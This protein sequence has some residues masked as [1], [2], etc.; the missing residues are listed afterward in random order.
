[1][2]QVK[3]PLQ[4]IRQ[5]NNN[6]PGPGVPFTGKLG[7]NIAQGSRASENIGATSDRFDTFDI[8]SRTHQGRV[9][10]TTECAE[11]R[12]MKLSKEAMNDILAGIWNEESD[13]LCTCSTKSARSLVAS[14][15]TSVNVANKVIP[16]KP[17]KPQEEEEK[18]FVSKLRWKK[19]KEPEPEEES[20]WSSSDDEGE[21]RQTYF[22]TQKKFGFQLPVQQPDRAP[23][24]TTFLDEKIRSSQIE[25][26][27]EY[28]RELGALNDELTSGQRKAEKIKIGA[29]GYCWKSFLFYSHENWLDPNFPYGYLPPG[30]SYHVLTTGGI[31]TLDRLLEWMRLLMPTVIEMEKSKYNLRIYELTWKDQVIHITAHPALHSVKNKST[32]LKTAGYASLSSLPDES[33]LLT[34][35][36]LMRTFK[37]MWQ[38]GGCV[39]KEKKGKITLTPKSRSFCWHELIYYKET[40]LFQS[41]RKKPPSMIRWNQGMSNKTQNALTRH[42]ELLCGGSYTFAMEKREHGIRVKQMRDLA[43]AINIEKFIELAEQHG[44]SYLHTR[45]VSEP[46]CWHLE[47]VEPAVI[48]IDYSHNP[49]D[50]Y[51]THTDLV[52]CIYGAWRGDYDF[53]HARSAETTEIPLIGIDPGYLLENEFKTALGLA[54]GDEASTMYV[55]A[56]DDHDARVVNNAFARIELVKVKTAAPDKQLIGGAYAKSTRMTFVGNRVT[57]ND[58]NYEFLSDVCASYAYNN[59]VP[60]ETLWGEETQERLLNQDWFILGNIKNKTR[61]YVTTTPDLSNTVDCMFTHCIGPVIGTADEGLL[62]ENLGWYKYVGGQLRWAMNNTTLAQTCGWETP[63]YRGQESVEVNGIHVQCVARRRFH[64]LQIITLTCQKYNTLTALDIADAT[65]DIPIFSTVGALAS[66][67]VPIITTKSVTLNRDLL[68]RLMTK[69]VTGKVS[70]DKLLEYGM[71]LSWFSYSKRGVEISNAKVTD[72]DVYTHVYVAKILQARE[73]LY[74][75]VTSTLTSPGLPRVLL[76]AAAAMFSDAMSTTDLLDRVRTSELLSKFMN[77]LKTPTIRNATGIALKNWLSI[78]AWSRA[79]TVFE[80]YKDGVAVC[81]HHDWCVTDVTGMYCS[82]CHSPTASREGGRCECCQE[83]PTFCFHETHRSNHVIGEK[84]C[85]CC[86]LKSEDDICKDCKVEV[87]Q[88]TVGSKAEQQIQGAR[89]F[90]VTRPS[91]QPIAINILPVSMAAMATIVPPNAYNILSKRCHLHEV[92]HIEK[93]TERQSVIPFIELGHKMEPLA[94]FTI[95]EVQDAGVGECGLDCINYYVAGLVSESAAFGITKKT[96]NFS[97]RDLL[98]ILAHFGLNGAVADA[99]GVSFRRCSDRE[100]F[101]TIVHTK[102]V[103]VEDDIQHWRIA[104]FKW[105]EGATCSMFAASLSSEDTHVTSCRS[106]FKKPWDVATEEEKCYVAYVLIRNQEVSIKTPLG[107]PKFEHG[108]LL[109]SSKHDPKNGMYNFEV[110]T[111]LASYARDMTVALDTRAVPDSLI[112]IWDVSLEHI[113]DVWHNVRNSFRDAC[114]AMTLF[115]N[116]PMK[117][118][119]AQVRPV[120]TTV[121]DQAH[122]VDVSDMKLKN[123]DLVMVQRRTSFT[124]YVV[125]VTNNRISVESKHLSG[126]TTMTIVKPKASFMSQIMRLI[127]LCS[128]KMTTGELRDMFQA[129]NIK[130]LKGMGGTGKTRNLVETLNSG[131]EKTLAIACTSGARKTL[132]A[133]TKP[134]DNLTLESF[135]KATYKTKEDYELIVIDEGTLIRPWELALVCK[136]FKRLIVAGDPTQISDVDFSPSGGQRWATNLLDFLG[137]SHPTTSLTKTYRFGEGLVRELKKHEALRTI[138]CG[139]DKITGVTMRHLPAWRA[140]EILEMALQVD[141]VIVFYNDH[142]EKMKKLLVRHT[143]PTVSTIGSFQGEGAKTVLVIQAPHV[144]ADIHLNFGYCFSA[145]TRCEEQLIWL[146]IDCFEPT[147][148]LH[149]RIGSRIGCDPQWFACYSESGPQ[150]LLIEGEDETREVVIMESFEQL[151][152]DVDR[153]IRHRE[154]D[155]ECFDFEL[156]CRAITHY[157]PFVKCETKFTNS[158]STFVILFRSM[159]LTKDLTFD[160]KTK[161][162]DLENAPGKY[163]NQLEALLC[164]CCIP[165]TKNKA[166]IVYN[167][168]K[169]G[170]YRMRILCWLIKAYKANG[171]QWQP[172]HGPLSNF[173]FSTI[174]NACAACSGL[175]ITQGNSE[176]VVNHDYLASNSRAVK[177]PHAELFC[178]EIEAEK[179][180]M[181]PDLFDDPELSHAI[182]TERIMTWFKDLSH[183]GT[184]LQNWMWYHKFDNKLLAA[185][186]KEDMGITVETTNYDDMAA[187]P[188]VSSN[189]AGIKSYLKFKRKKWQVSM[190][191]PDTS[192]RKIKEYDYEPDLQ[193]LVYISLAHL[194]SQMK[195]KPECRLIATG[196]MKR[197]GAETSILPGMAENFEWHARH[198]TRTLGIVRNKLAKLKISALKDETKIIYVPST[199]EEYLSEHIKDRGFS[200]NQRTSPSD[201]GPVGCT[202]ALLRRVRGHTSG[203]IHSEG[204]C[205]YSAYVMESENITCYWDSSSDH[206]KLQTRLDRPVYVAMLKYHGRRLPP[207]GAEYKNLEKEVMGEGPWFTP[208]KLSEKK[209]VTLSASAN[210][211]SLSAQTVAEMYRDWKDIFAWCPM[212][213][214]RQGNNKY[215][216]C[217]DSNRVYRVHDDQYDALVNGKYLIN[218]NL[219]W[220][221][222]SMMGT[223][224]VLRLCT[225]PVWVDNLKLSNSLIIVRVPTIILDP[226]QALVTGNILSFS[227]KSFNVDLLNNLLRRCLRPGTTFDDL[228]VQLRTLINTAQFSTHT[229]SSKYKTNVA[230]GKAT[231]RLAWMT[232][233]ATVHQYSILGAET[234]NVIQPQMIGALLVGKAVDKATSGTE[235]EDGLSKLLSVTGI[236][237][238]KMPMLMK[239]VMTTLKNLSGLSTCLRSHKRRVVLGNHAVMDW[240][241]KTMLSANQPL[242]EL[243]EFTG[244]GYYWRNDCAIC[245]KLMGMLATQ[246]IDKRARALETD[247]LGWIAICSP[248]CRHSANRLEVAYWNDGAHGKDTLTLGT[249]DSPAAVDIRVSPTTNETMISGADIELPTELHKYVVGQEYPTATNCRIHITGLTLEVEL[250]LAAVFNSTIIYSRERECGMFPEYQNNEVLFL[251]ANGVLQEKY[252]RKGFM[253]RPH[254]SAKAL[255]NIDWTICTPGDWVPVEISTNKIPMSPGEAALA[256]TKEEFM[257]LY[258]LAIGVKRADLERTCW[259]RLMPVPEGWSTAAWVHHGD[260]PVPGGFIAHVELLFEYRWGTLGWNAGLREEQGRK[261]M[262]YTR[263]S[264]KRILDYPKESRSY[265]PETGLKQLTANLVTLEAKGN[266]KRYQPNKQA[267]NGTKINQLG[268]HADCWGLVR[269]VGAVC[270]ET[271]AQYLEHNYERGF[272]YTSQT[273]AG[274]ETTKTQEDVRLGEL[275]E[276]PLVNTLPQD[277]CKH[278]SGHDGPRLTVWYNPLAASLLGERLGPGRDLLSTTKT[279]FVAEHLASG[280]ALTT[281]MVLWL[282]AFREKLYEMKLHESAIVNLY[283]LCPGKAMRSPANFPGRHVHIGARDEHIT[284]LGY[285]TLELLQ[286][287]GRFGASLRVLAAMLLPG[288]VLRMMRS[289]RPSLHCMYSEEVLSHLH[290]LGALTNRNTVVGPWR[291]FGPFIDGMALHKPIS[292]ANLSRFCAAN[293]NYGHVYGMDEANFDWFELDTCYYQPANQ[294][295]YSNMPLNPQL[296]QVQESINMKPI[297]DEMCTRSTLP[298]SLVLKSTTN[299]AELWPLVQALDPQV[300]DDSRGSPTSSSLSGRDKKLM[301][302][303]TEQAQETV[304]EPAPQNPAQVNWPIGTLSL[305]YDS[306][307]TKMG[308]GETANLGAVETIMSPDQMGG[309]VRDVWVHATRLRRSR[310]REERKKFVLDELTWLNMLR[311]KQYEDTEKIMQLWGAC[312]LNVGLITG[313]HFKVNVIN[314]GPIDWLRITAHRDGY[315][316]C[317]LVSTTRFSWS[318]VTEIKFVVTKIKSNQRPRD[319][320]AHHRAHEIRNLLATEEPIPKT[321]EKIADK[322][323]NG[324][325]RLKGRFDIVMQSNRGIIREECTTCLVETEDANK[326]HG[327]FH[328]TLIPGRLYL[329]G[330]GQSL[331]WSVATTIDD[332]TVICCESYPLVI[333]DVGVALDCPA[334]PLDRQILTREVEQLGFINSASKKWA[335]WHDWNAGVSVNP[336]A[337][338]VL[339]A[340]FDNVNH[341]AR[342]D[343]DHMLDLARTRV[344]FP[345]EEIWDEALFTALGGGG[346]IR[347]GVEDGLPKLVTAANKPGD[348]QSL[349]RI[350]DI[351]ELETEFNYPDVVAAWDRVA[352][353]P[354]G[355]RLEPQRAQVLLEL[356]EQ[357]HTLTDTEYEENVMQYTLIEHQEGTRINHIV[358]QVYEF[359]NFVNDDHIYDIRVDT[360]RELTG[361][362]VLEQLSLSDPHSFLTLTFS[363]IGAGYAKMETENEAILIDELGHEGAPEFTHSGKETKSSSEEQIK[364]DAFDEKITPE[365]EQT[366]LSI[367][368]LNETMFVDPDIIMSTTFPD[369]TKVY[370]QDDLIVGGGTATDPITD[371]VIQEL[372][373]PS[374]INFWDDETGMIETVLD[375][376]KEDIRLR[377][378]EGFGGIANVIKLKTREWPTHAQGIYNSKL[379]G[380]WQAVS[381]LFGNVL[382]LREVNRD[383]KTDADRFRRIYFKTGSDK[384]LKPVGWNTATI[385]DWLST[386]PDGLSITKEVDQILSEGFDVHGLDQVN[387]HTKLESRM[388]D[389]MSNLLTVSPLDEN[390]YT[391]TISEQVSRLIVWQRKGITAL[392]SAGFLQAKE[393]LKRVL[394]PQVIYSDGYTPRQLSAR[395]NKLNGEGVTFV[396]DDLAKQDRQTDMIQIETEMLIYE[397]LGCSKQMI[398]TW[399]KVHRHWKAKG[400]NIRFD[401]DAG[402]LTGQASTSIGNTI[403]NLNV[404]ADFVERFMASLVIM[405]VLGDDNM[406]IIRGV[407]T[408]EEVMLHSARQHNMVSKPVIS[409]VGGNFL[410]MTVYTNSNGQLEVGPDFVRMSRRHQVFNGNG[411][412]PEVN[413]AIGMGPGHGKT[414]LATRNPLM[415]VDHEELCDLQVMNSFNEQQQRAETEFELEKITTKK[416]AYISSMATIEKTRGRILLTWT[417]KLVSSKFFYVTTLVVKTRTSQD[418]FRGEQQRK[419]EKRFKTKTGNWQPSQGVTF[420]DSYSTSEKFL[421]KLFNGKMVGSRGNICMARNLSYCAMLGDLSCV[422]RVVENYKWPLKLEMWYEYATVVKVLANKYSTTEDE[423]EGL[424]NHLCLDMKRATMIEDVKLVFGEKENL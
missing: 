304:R 124:P 1:M 287:P 291:T 382:H 296:R 66:A 73:D 251:S 47:W 136:S 383:P 360:Y 411:G 321:F 254:Y 117:Y 125:T 215:L 407:V 356:L 186:L 270:P 39:A 6:T 235:L 168:G 333:Y 212:E 34:T 25:D 112:E 31:L 283:S 381:T 319:R 180:S 253:I 390:G 335:D 137:K 244:R 123:G 146:S 140:Q 415:F 89:S 351:I 75:W 139:T 94:N 359:D 276:L 300:P 99:T 329:C 115:V 400:V 368:C 55:E 307:P 22:Q 11:M 314:N 218:T 3:Q 405:L 8:R 406:M 222:V 205:I 261:R 240:A 363:P 417:E 23:R 286:D 165:G 36:E 330:N 259:E 288:T 271:G 230:D 278:L 290:S 209:D 191:D 246:A 126:L 326:V 266:F 394:I 295:G 317:A 40:H 275:L 384:W 132:M 258:A 284:N 374:T 354:V 303:L 265:I 74:D 281:T 269:L 37:E 111:T 30:S 216:R 353:K 366:L 153:G 41:I 207:D 277:M 133:G 228:L 362:L 387:I 306:L 56:V 57:T 42:A 24:Y 257:E 78:D 221:T 19:E 267:P 197:V 298:L 65:F 21:P 145:A 229:V 263:I 404:H 142:V 355:N 367:D 342:P 396:E 13:N 237:T 120:L 315:S 334:A 423:I 151:L 332:M 341:H 128:I 64:C 61:Y 161:K 203:R 343:R 420:T 234:N 189:H 88:Y 188:Y 206:D 399:K 395:L 299:H 175:K 162:F 318:D 163:K 324:R 131:T 173:N 49:R 285:E 289:G 337:E 190:V 293:F 202:L 14:S 401:G 181:V 364:R 201:P 27:V 147:D 402:R 256:E 187:Y 148:P 223:I 80:L 309:C 210:I 2:E 170:K 63:F 15:E 159:G 135:E 410:R 166:G 249:L 345:D 114:Y 48:E 325:I 323:S 238:E 302:E 28:V 297:G 122:Y 247:P 10:H 255:E 194:C 273:N 274:V 424:L 45:G 260:E 349:K 385:R 4:T 9:V 398:A 138:E 130:L 35:A 60:E 59:V 204:P 346:P 171:K 185:H 198:K 183:G 102:A 414:T 113:D 17:S 54:V 82:C 196:Y 352:W 264:R 67:G 158:K 77:V 84:T 294:H 169:R 69:N 174:G 101:A 106:L 141:K 371:E 199:V 338:R 51:I 282:S 409:K 339:V 193:E 105:A 150:R 379:H 178:D 397:M 179:W 121:H 389:V 33:K 225:G 262:T 184:G 231:A 96:R 312:G 250:F 370:E 177:G 241:D 108:K 12:L 109:N 239:V 245:N 167:L 143:K 268:Q 149:K 316:H 38:L 100:A 243:K 327:W 412:Q 116:D 92:S 322:I 172:A 350:C 79:T 5:H 380:G 392:F 76:S 32:D 103:N 68:N 311:I 340:R 377:Q 344:R 219:K 313:D 331:D 155:P 110:P 7:T 386:R 418:G 107:L 301:D 391:T 408:R 305:P 393:N 252:G 336:S 118:G 365:L 95:T 320:L 421:I 422:K 242:Y 375:L 378:R 152:H 272:Y 348:N 129:S 213:F 83:L 176:T 18:P 91:T 50:D 134:R 217:P 328:H 227:E 160:N 90:P 46:K 182:L 224:R 292:H 211:L 361:E 127:S 98:G 226:E 58:N 26:C 233:L 52:K 16:S 280:A 72:E 164:N 236:S 157:A 81:S 372:P 376:P 29:G 70:Q 87:M 232:H 220:H 214:D 347:L 43:L 97:A 369:D 62:P 156:F 416:N 279:H 71:A 119:R 154:F 388:K 310:C 373:N 86:N 144:R 413:L 308:R 208:V 53:E 195:T 93:D 104:R 192:R 85:S 403:V 248:Q 357:P 358:K 200:S 20:D 44:S 419:F